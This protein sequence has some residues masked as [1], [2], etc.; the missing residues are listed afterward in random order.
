MIDLA[1]D[2]VPNTTKGFSPVL[3]KATKFPTNI[4][5][6]LAIKILGV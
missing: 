2:I 4:T 5:H 1:A 3:M 6:L